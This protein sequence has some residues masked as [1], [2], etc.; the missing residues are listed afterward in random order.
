MMR[1]LLRDNEVWQYFG[2][3]MI[4]MLFSLGS[5]GMIANDIADSKKYTKPPLQ[6][7]VA[8]LISKGVPD[9]DY[10]TITGFVAK[11]FFSRI[12]EKEN[13]DGK[14][15]KTRSMVYFLLPDKTSFLEERPKVNVIVHQALPTSTCVET[16]DCLTPGET[17][18][19]G[20]ISTSEGKTGFTPAS[21][22][23]GEKY[24]FQRKDMTFLDATWR[25]DKVNMV[26]FS[27]IFAAVMWLLTGLFWAWQFIRPAEPE[28]APYIVTA[29]DFGITPTP[30]KPPAPKSIPRIDDG[31]TSELASKRTLEDEKIFEAQ[32]GAVLGRGGK[33]K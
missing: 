30:R 15:S 20:R 11:D 5:L 29:S 18:V 2:V 7:T 12:V 6:I 8:D 1:R 24:D 21:Y 13:R 26:G 14:T 17:I 22:K 28:E 27:V 16:E 4:L 3:G 31:L 33:P 10:V 23:L 32:H 9:Y 25:P 19:T